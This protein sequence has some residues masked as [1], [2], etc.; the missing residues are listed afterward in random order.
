MMSAV[1]ESVRGQIEGRFNQVV[2]DSPRATLG[3]EI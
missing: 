3:E 2:H 1:V